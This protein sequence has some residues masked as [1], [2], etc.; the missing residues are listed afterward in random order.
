MDLL[1][2]LAF[3][4]LTTVGFGNSWR[5]FIGVKGL[6]L[7][8][9]KFRLGSLAKLRTPNSRKAGVFVR[10]PGPVNFVRMALGLDLPLSKICP[11]QLIAPNCPAKPV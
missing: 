11:D 3:W 9:N 10:T 6:I 5:R 8:D 2:D 4:S 1:I 7:S